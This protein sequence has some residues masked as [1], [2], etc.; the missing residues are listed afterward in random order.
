MN[1]T[2]GWIERNRRHGDGRQG[3]YWV[4]RGSEMLEWRVIRSNRFEKRGK[5]ILRERGRWNSEFAMEGE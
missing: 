4:V 3:K 5:V 1:I 2:K